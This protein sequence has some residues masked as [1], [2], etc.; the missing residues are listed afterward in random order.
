MSPYYTT[1]K[2]EA[3]AAARHLPTVPVAAPAELLK[4]THYVV[5]VYTR[6]VVSHLDLDS[7]RSLPTPPRSSIGALSGEYLVAFDM[8]LRS[9]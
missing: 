8:K 3:Q 2:E 7:P 4:D 1:G 9:T 5:G 6:P